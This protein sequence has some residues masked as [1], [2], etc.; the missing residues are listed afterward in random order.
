MKI[1]RTM[2]MATAVAGASTEVGHA[3]PTGLPAHQAT[4]APLVLK[5]HGCHRSA[6]DSFEGWHRHVGPYCDWVR[7]SRS[8]SNPYARCRTRCQYIGPIKT[9]KRVCY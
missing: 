3:A 4:T 1:W 5:T 2:L 6:Q 7:A 8:R 9:C